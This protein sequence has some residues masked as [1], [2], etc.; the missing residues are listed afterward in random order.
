M[1]RNI[2]TIGTTTMATVSVACFLL[3]VSPAR[4]GLTNQET[5]ET[6]WGAGC[7]PGGENPSGSAGNAP[8]ASALPSNVTTEDCTGADTQ[9]IGD[10][11]IWLKNNLPLIDAKMAQS[12]HL[13]SWPGNSREN[14]QEKLDK[15]LKFVCI[16][17]KNK[18][19]DLYGIVY[20]VFAQKRVNLCTT[21]IND[22]ANGSAHASSALYIQTISHEIG[23]LI[24]L[25]AHG[26]DC[27]K[28]YEEPGFSHAVGFAAEYAFRNIPYDPAVY[29]AGCSS[30]PQPVVITDKFGNEI[31]IQAEK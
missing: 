17:Q 4:A 9:R 31:P 19:D 21:N 8:S 27:W 24:R 16:N 23:H 1:V 28:R 11:I 7:L 18:C 5:G 14:F 26:S 6:C 20:P 12:S 25:N 22:D 29:T 2:T 13:M 15:P 30:A 10:A 3:S